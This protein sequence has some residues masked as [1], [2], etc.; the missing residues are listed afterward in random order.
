MFQND[1]VTDAN[2]N[3]GYA[4]F[5]GTLLSDNTYRFNISRY[6]QGLITRH[7]PNDTMRLYAPL[8]TNLYNSNF[9]TTLTLPVIDAIAKGRVVLGGSSHAD[10]TMRLRL[11][12]IYSDL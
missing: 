9:K 11:R 4:S 3:I 8:R 6:V 2:G 7:E 10:S 5:G 1:L 12:I